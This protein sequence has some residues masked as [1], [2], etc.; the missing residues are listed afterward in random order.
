MYAQPQAY[1]RAAP[2]YGQPRPIY[3]R[4]APVAAYP[5]QVQPG[6]AQPQAYPRPMGAQP[7]YPGVRPMGQP[8]YPT[9]GVQGRQIYGAAMGGGMMQ[10][11]MIVQQPV[12]L[13]QQEPSAVVDGVAYTM[14][15]LKEEIQNLKRQKRRVGLGPRQKQRF[16]ALKQAK[17][18][19]KN[20]ED[21]DDD[22]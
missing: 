9:A 20:L 4:G 19:L 18:Q 17:K 16:R 12:V 15:M 11:G 10:P 3:P 1:P 14:H 22:W 8:A 21:D 5:G 6:Y 13:Q 2:V 7:M